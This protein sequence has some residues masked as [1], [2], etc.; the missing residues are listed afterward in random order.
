M[1]GRPHYPWSEGDALFADELNAAIANAGG[2]GGPFLPLTGGTVQTLFSDPTAE[3]IGTNFFVGTAMTA[4]NPQD[5]ISLVSRYLPNTGGHHMTSFHGSAIYGVATPFDNAP[6]GT[7][8]GINAVMAQS[9][10]Q[11]EGTVTRAVDFYGHANVNNAG[12]ILTNHYYLFQETSTGAVNH[13]GGF[14]SAPVGIGTITPAFN[15][16]IQGPVY[17]LTGN[18]FRAGNF[19]VTSGGASIYPGYNPGPGGLGLLDLIVGNNGVAEATTSTSAFLYISSC[20]GTPTG[21]PLRAATGRVAMRYDT[22]AHKLWMHDGTSWR[23][24]VLT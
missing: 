24:V 14:F 20:A 5:I 9:G 4:D 17:N 21:F 16:D 19:A 23:G 2:G 13:Y 18:W 12:G 3:S 22:T 11:G 15:L 8:D 7:I 6:G 10:N 1:S